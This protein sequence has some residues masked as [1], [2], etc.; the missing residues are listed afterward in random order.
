MTSPELEHVFDDT[1]GHYLPKKNTSYR[2]LIRFILTDHSHYG[3][4]PIIVQYDFGALDGPYIHDALFEYCNEWNT[5]SLKI[6]HI[7]EMKLTFRNHRFYHG[8]TREVLT[9]TTINS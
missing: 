4:Q 6:A 1:W 3:C 7:Y 9:S 5:E 8:K 2:G